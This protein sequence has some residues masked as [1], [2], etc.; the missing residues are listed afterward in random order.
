MLVA[1]LLLLLVSGYGTNGLILDPSSVP[2]QCHDL[3]TLINQKIGRIESVMNSK[4]ERIA[5]LE[6][7]LK[8]QTSKISTLESLMDERDGSFS[9]LMK[10]V[11]GVEERVNNSNSSNGDVELNP[12]DNTKFHEEIPNLAYVVASHS[13][14]FDGPDDNAQDNRNHGITRSRHQNRVGTQSNV[15]FH[16]YLT[17]RLNLPTQAAVIF[18]HEV[19]DNRNGYNPRDGIYLVPETGTYVITW[20]MVSLGRSAFQ[21]LLVVNGQT[22]GRTWT[23]AEEIADSHQATGIVVLS[24]NQGDHLFIRMGHVYH[25]GIL[26]DSS[27]ANPTF[28]GWKIY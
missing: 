26:A 4:D 8:A 3:V 16:A 1:A 25:G 22:R 21:T 15:A 20:T 5:Q 13:M 14:E 12:P 18:D 27:Y 11:V 7:K 6:I 19:L 9:N 23:D 28:S 17:S 2:I 10:R 24:L